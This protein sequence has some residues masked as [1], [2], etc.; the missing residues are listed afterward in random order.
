MTTVA[1]PLCCTATRGQ[2]RMIQPS[3]ITRVLAHDDRHPAALL[4]CN[5]SDP[6]AGGGLVVMGQECNYYGDLDRTGLAPERDSRSGA[7]DAMLRA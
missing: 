2:A 5:I 1:R 7:S 3:E 6:R 4:H